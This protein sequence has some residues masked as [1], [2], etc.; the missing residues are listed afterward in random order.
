[1]DVMSRPRSGASRFGCTGLLLVVALLA[2]FSSAM[3]AF[4]TRVDERRFPWAYAA[5]GRSTLTGTWIGSLTT[6]RGET[7]ALY[8]DLRLQPLNFSTRG[9]RRRGRA[10]GRIYRRATS[11]KLVGELRMCGG[12]ATEQ[13]FTL[14]GNN[15]DEQ[16]SQFRLSFAV[17]DSTPSNGLAPSHLQGR[18]NARDS[19]AIAADLYVR[20]GASAI[21]DSADP[22]TGRPASGGLHRGTEAEFRALC[23]RIGG[24]R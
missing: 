18:W 16:A 2:I 12:A 23:G 14:H 22:D 24:E 17:A 8:L 6:G 4:W 10:S 20:R 9:G 15:L 11:D 19:L 13:R 5:A 7:R 21:T 1:M 3:Q